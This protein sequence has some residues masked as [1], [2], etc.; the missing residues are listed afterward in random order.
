MMLIFQKLNLPNHH[1]AKIYFIDIPGSKQSAMR[2]G[3]LTIPGGSPEFYQLNVVNNKLGGME[4]RLMRTLREEKGYTY[5][6][7]SFL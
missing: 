4:A 1:P 2:I 6:A 3:T 5:G 7:G